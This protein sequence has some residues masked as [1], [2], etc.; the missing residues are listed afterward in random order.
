MSKDG[1]LVVWEASLSL[2]QMQQHIQSAEQRRRR[3]REGEE[4]QGEVIQNSST[5]EEGLGVDESSEEEGED[6]STVAMEMDAV[7]TRESSG[8]ESGEYH[9]EVLWSVCEIAGFWQ[10]K[11][12]SV[13]V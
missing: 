1:A 6:K 12:R 4:Q 3:R 7:L 2:D 5:R 11:K 8:D 10:R 9:T 13:K